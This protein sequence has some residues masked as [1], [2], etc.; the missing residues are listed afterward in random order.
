MRSGITIVGTVCAVTVAACFFFYPALTLVKLAHDSGIHKDGQPADFDQWFI[1]TAKRYRRW[2]QGYLATRQAEATAVND[3]AGTEWP[4]F[5][6]VF[7]LASADELLQQ[8]KIERDEEMMSA[9]DLAVRVVTDPSTAT[10]VQA[11]WG[12]DY[13]QRENLFYRMLVLHGLTSYERATGDRRF[14]AV[15]QEQARLLAAELM[16]ATHHL[17]DDYPGECYPTDVLWAVVAIQRSLGEEAAPLARELVNVLDGKL[18]TRHGLPAFSVDSKTGKTYEGSRGSGNS[19]MLCL[20]GELAP[21]V[22]Q[23]W[24]TSYVE[25][26]WTTGMVRGFRE[27]PLG[28]ANV[29]DVDSGPVLFGLG[30]V[31]S[32]FGIGAARANGRFDHASTLAQEVLAV[33]WPTPF[34]LLLP[35]V[36]GWLAADGWCFG[37]LALS[38]AMTRPTYAA[39]TRPHDGSVPPLVW[40]MSTFYFGVGTLISIREVT[41]WRARLRA[42]RRLSNPLHR[43]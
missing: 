11:K 28:E 23:R 19:G 35:G 16:A 13:A 22:A 43:Q 27:V 20:A 26:H 37:E 31:A 40:L 41:F 36:M 17:L 5:G 2:A 34:G 3:V 6:T 7:F 24:Y 18:R 21:D 39:V 9:M 25:H 15:H 30:S 1:Q 4:L 38:F 10:W 8:G 42:G 12:P 14:H 29:M 32:L 33:S